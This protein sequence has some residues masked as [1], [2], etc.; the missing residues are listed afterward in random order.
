[1][2]LPSL[3]KNAVDLLDYLA[4]THPSSWVSRETARR[5]LCIDQKT[6][7]RACYRLVEWKLVELRRLPTNRYMRQ[8]RVTALGVDLVRAFYS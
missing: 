5:E 3:P 6:A 1:M 4:T 8:V 7:R 2:S